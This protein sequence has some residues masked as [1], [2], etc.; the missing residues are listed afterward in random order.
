MA[1][2]P[3]SVAQYVDKWKSRSLSN[4]ALSTHD[5]LLRAFELSFEELR[6]TSPM[7]ANLLLMFSFLDHRDM[8]YELCL[9]MA[10]ESSP[11]WLQHLSAHKRPRDYIAPLHDLSFIEAKPH[12]QLGCIYEI[13]PAVHEFARW[14][15]G[16][17]EVEY[18]TTAITL[19]A[20]R[21]PRSTDHDFIAITQRLEPHVSQCM[22]YIQQ[23][24]T[25]DRLDL[26]ELEKFGNLFRHVGRY[27]EAF[28]LYRVVL[29]YLRTDEPSQFNLEMMANI[30]NNIGLV[31]HAKREYEKALQAYERSSHLRRQCFPSPNQ[32]TLVSTFYNEGRSLL[33]LSKLEDAQLKLS[34]AADY[35]Y[36]AMN[37]ESRPRG[38]REQLMHPYQRILNDL[39]E[40]HLRIGELEKAE[41]VLH[42]AF[43]GHL[44]A[45]R[46]Q[47]P[48]AFA[49]R[50]NM[51]RVCAE[52]NFFAS[53]RRIFEHI[54]ATY[55]EWWG[56]RHPETVRALNEL[57]ESYMRH[58]KLKR[59]MGD[60]S[61]D[62][63]KRSSECFTETLLFYEETFG[64]EAA[65][66]GL[67][68]SKLEEL[69]WLRSSIAKSPYEIYYAPPQP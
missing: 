28:Q 48:T 12:D 38:E 60:G 5:A 53:S 55:T 64:K 67:I 63:L 20:A 9:G 16:D 29:Q 36:Q 56:R 57:A 61:E 13:H 11:Q 24:R 23:D 7:S 31:H 33:V 4:E 14:K 62:E 3:Q 17:D 44:E 50:L 27:D 68:R 54:I 25:G 69:A 32:D 51:G 65:I 18:L 58:G 46:E 52:R 40:T 1:R 66:V 47:H 2:N 10:D 6:K 37:D 19:V 8:W 49:I 15:T 30:E 42:K 43:R 39:G 35:F 59:E 26:V 34:A 45:G 21:V 41:Q 22:L